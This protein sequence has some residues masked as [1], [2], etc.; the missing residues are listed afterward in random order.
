M[1]F[2]DRPRAL[3]AKLVSTSKVYSSVFTK[4]DKLLIRKDTTSVPCPALCERSQIREVPLHAPIHMTF[5][6]RHNQRVRKQVNGCLGS[7]VREGLTTK[8]Q[9]RELLD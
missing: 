8:G 6:E 3:G 1:G 2:W 9:R 4:R 5:S 7:G